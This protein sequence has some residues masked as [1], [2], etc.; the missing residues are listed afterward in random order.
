MRMRDA[1]S[2]RLAEWPAGEVQWVPVAQDFADRRVA[3]PGG[4]LLAGL[5]GFT[6]KLREGDRVAVAVGSRGISSIVEV[7][8]SLVGWL[9]SRGADPFI[10]PAMGSHGGGSAEGQVEVLAALGI[11]EAAMGVAIVSSLD[12]VQ[13]GVTPG[14]V[15]VFTDRC[16]WTADLVIPVARIKPHTDFHG[17]I[18]SGPTKMLAIGLGNRQG[19]HSIHSV[20]LAKLSQTISD[21]GQIVARALKVP[22]CIGIVEDAFEN[23]AIVEV[24]PAEALDSREPELLALARDWMPYLPVAELDVLVVQ[25]MGKNISGDGMD[26]N[27]TG[28]FYDPQF[29]SG[30]EVQRLVTLDLTQETGGNACGMGMADIVTA[31]LAGKVDWHQTYTNEVTAGTPHGARLP[32]VALDDEEA[33]AI[34]V[35]TLSSVPPRRARLAWI[36]N[37]LSLSRLLVS[38]PVLDA[39]SGQVRALADPAPI[40]FDAGTLTLP[41]L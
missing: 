5:S 41:D 36:Q 16:A 31:R 3:A 15:P 21:A 39:V 7:C 33:L 1:S 28:R 18:E 9:K 30:P 11:T 32:M 24:I 2:P 38:V 25:Q 26:P 6:G 13:L 20:G 10:V 8:R 19:A 23:A 22:F 17:R 35:G 27:I 4:D 34:A 37:T 40:T 29:A 12:T 14:G